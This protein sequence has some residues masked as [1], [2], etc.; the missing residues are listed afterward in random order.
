MPTQFL[1]EIC[2]I[3]ILSPTLN[4]GTYTITELITYMMLVRNKAIFLVQ[5]M[6]AV[7]SIYLFPWQCSVLTYYPIKHRH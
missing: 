5:T 7:L 4:Q 3:R 6:F 1:P 2:L